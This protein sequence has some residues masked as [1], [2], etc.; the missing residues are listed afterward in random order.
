MEEEKLQK[1]EGGVARVEGGG[2]PPP[3][4]WDLGG[5]AAL[6]LPLGGG[7]QKYLDYHCL[8]TTKTKIKITV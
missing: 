8:E 1:F 2:R 7:V 3:L 4:F 5:G 6:F